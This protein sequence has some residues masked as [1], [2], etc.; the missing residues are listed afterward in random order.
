VTFKSKKIIA[1][2]YDYDSIASEMGQATQAIQYCRNAPPIKWL[3]HDGW[4]VVS[5]AIVKLAMSLLT[6]TT[7]SRGDARRLGL[8]GWTQPS[9]FTAASDRARMVHNH[10]DEKRGR[11]R[12]ER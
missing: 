6:T 9:L 12:D 3:D 2:K 10:H 1:R 4:I 11:V 8:M 5:D 7:V